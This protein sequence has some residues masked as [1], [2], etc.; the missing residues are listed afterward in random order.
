MPKFWIRFAS[1]NSLDSCEWEETECADMEAAEK[2]AWERACEDYESYVGLYGIRE[3]ATIMEE[4]DVDEEQAEQTFLDERE[5]CLN[6][7]V[8]DTEPPEDE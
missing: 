1:I 2:E 5:S 8:R 7:E 6:Y 4:D 3:A